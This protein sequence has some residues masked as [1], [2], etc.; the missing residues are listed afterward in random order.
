MHSQRNS[1]TLYGVSALLGTVTGHHPE[2]GKGLNRDATIVGNLAIED[3]ILE[4]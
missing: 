2:T 3:A 1:T 4:P